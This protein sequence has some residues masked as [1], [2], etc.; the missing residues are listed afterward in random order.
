MHKLPSAA[1]CYTVRQQTE[2]TLQKKMKSIS[3]VGGAFFTWH[4]VQCIFFHV[5][6]QRSFL[7]R[8]FDPHSITTCTPTIWTRLSERW[9]L[10][11]MLCVYAVAHD[12]CQS[13]NNNLHPAHSHHHHHW[14]H[15]SHAHAYIVWTSQT[16]H[17]N[18]Q[19][20]WAENNIEQ[21]YHD[22]IQERCDTHHI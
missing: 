2:A 4:F 6:S 19:L 17:T 8:H 1:K 15:M 16:I 13:G 12:C 21:A 10:P 11:T 7:R 3:T 9:S 20:G 14:N 18:K 22:V 5:I